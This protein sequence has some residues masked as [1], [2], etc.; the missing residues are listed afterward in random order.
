MT[1]CCQQAQATHTGN[2]IVLVSRK[3]AKET[4]VLPFNDT[5]A[6]EQAFKSQPDQ[7]GHHCR[8]ISR[9]LWTDSPHQDIWN[10]PS[11]LHGKYAVLIFDEVMTV[12]VLHWRSPGI[13]KCHSRSN[14]YGK[15]IEEVCLG[16]LRKQIRTNLLHLSRIPGWNLEGNPLAI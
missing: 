3:P 15:I 8:A 6:V 13:N 2:Q 4:V 12:F 14:G 1:A 16:H 10:H 9:K 5:Q 7:I 11:N